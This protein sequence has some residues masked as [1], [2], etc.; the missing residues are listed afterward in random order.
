M[1]CGLLMNIRKDFGSILLR[2]S[3][4]TQSWQSI[5]R[6]LFHRGGCGGVSDEHCKG[7]GSILLCGSSITQP[8]QS[9][10]RVLFHR[11]GC[12]VGV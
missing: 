3:S 4:I 6:V 12:G 5:V 8:W 7:F 10:V 9:I 11:R 2:G 1:R